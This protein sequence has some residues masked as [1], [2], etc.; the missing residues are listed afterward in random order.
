[1]AGTGLRTSLLSLGKQGGASPAENRY[2][3]LVLFDIAEQKKYRLLMRRLK[4]YAVRIQKSVFEAWLKPRQIRDMSVAIER[5]M[6]LER[7]FDSDDNVRIYRMAGNCDVTVFGECRTA[8]AES[9][10]FV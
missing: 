9:D 8:Q 3:V 4:R 1:M 5:L 7:Y 2:Y 6:S 10:I